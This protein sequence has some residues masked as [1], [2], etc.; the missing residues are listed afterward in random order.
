MPPKGKNHPPAPQGE[1]LLY[2]VHPV[3]EALAHRQEEIDEI[4]VCGQR[5]G[6]AQLAEEAAELGVL[7]RHRPRALLD[8]WVPQ[9]NHQGVVAR[10]RSFAYLELEELLEQDPTG[11]LLLLSGIQDP[12]NLG[13]LLRSARGFG[14]GG[15][16]LPRRGTCGVTPAVVRA[17][18]GATESLPIARVRQLPATLQR[19]KEAGWWVLGLAPGGTPLAAFDLVRPTLFL[20]GAEGGG[21][22]PSLQKHCDA[23]LQIPMAA[24]WDS[25]N[26]A[27]AGA[28]ALYEWRRQNPLP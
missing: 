6:A 27:V 1:R 15:V 13:S 12:G 3:R 10:L 18:A 21:L 4:V 20:L 19:L 8:R 28:V 17:S 26:V 9:G 24:Q 11:P 25:L 14:A 2:G 5:G 23:F 7:V 16:L 22:P